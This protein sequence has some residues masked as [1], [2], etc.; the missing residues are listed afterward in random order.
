MIH[1]KNAPRLLDNLGSSRDFPA[2]DYVGGEGERK[3][4]LES[5]NFSLNSLT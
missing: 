1:H 3:G 4:E 5:P 2:C